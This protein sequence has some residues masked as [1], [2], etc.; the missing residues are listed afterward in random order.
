[1][2]NSAHDLGGRSGMGPINPEAEEQEPVFHTE[3]ERRVFGITMAAGMLGKWN[4]DEARHARE[5]QEEAD[6]LRH[7]Y[8][9]NWLV[10]LEA[11]L[12]ESGLVTAQELQNCEANSANPPPSDLRIPNPEDAKKILHR[13]GPANLPSQTE[14]LFKTG[15]SV[16]VAER[17]SSG[18]TRVPAYAQGVAGRINA[19]RGFHIF[20]DKSAHG[21]HQGEHLYSVVFSANALWEPGAENTEVFV[22]MWQPYLQRV[23]S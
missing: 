1:M 2:N 11:L 3:W 23:G 10:G 22:D 7:S 8:Y 14:P 5:R 13:G 6:Y 17:N 15:D 20:P 12:L 9:Q 18:H 21:S 4:I 19:Y 16:S